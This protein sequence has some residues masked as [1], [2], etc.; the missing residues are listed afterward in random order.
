MDGACSDWP[1]PIGI[2]HLRHA[3]STGKI[4][5]TTGLIFAFTSPLVPNLKKDRRVHD[6]PQTSTVETT[7]FTGP[8]RVGC[9]F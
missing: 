3:S 2:L 9:D 4:I 7:H 6:G 1:D 5:L 8:G